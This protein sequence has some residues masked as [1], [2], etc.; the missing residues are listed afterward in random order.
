MEN[1]EQLL[2]FNLTKIID[3]INS[4]SRNITIYESKLNLVIS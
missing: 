4:I 1:K 2:D 3:I